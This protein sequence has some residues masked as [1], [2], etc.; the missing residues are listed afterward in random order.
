LLEIKGFR[1]D[2]LE[3]PPKRAGIYKDFAPDRTSPVCAAGSSVIGW[4]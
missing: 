2:N 4:P 1:D 3:N